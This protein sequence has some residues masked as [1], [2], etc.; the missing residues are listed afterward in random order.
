WQAGQGNPQGPGPRRVP[1]TLGAPARPRR[2]NRR[3]QPMNRVEVVGADLARALTAERA[4]RTIDQLE[5]IGGGRSALTL[6]AELRGP[7]GRAEEVAG[8]AVPRHD[9]G[10]AIGSLSDQYHVLEL[11]AKTQVPAPK[12]ILVAE[13]IEGSTYDVLVTTYLAGDVPNPWRRAGR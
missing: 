2:G 12:P 10:L 5:L 3:N 1:A 11:V 9:R 8:R 13:D 7:G 4:G 6:R